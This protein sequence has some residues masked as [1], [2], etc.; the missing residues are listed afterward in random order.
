MGILSDVDIGSPSGKS[1]SQSGVGLVADNIIV[2]T[3]ILCH[4]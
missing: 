4:N 3:Q 1:M 2:K